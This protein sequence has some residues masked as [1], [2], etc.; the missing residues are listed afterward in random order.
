[1]TLETLKTHESVL[2]FQILLYSVIPS[3]TILL[4]NQNCYIFNIQTAVMD[5]TVSYLANIKYCYLSANMYEQ[6]SEFTK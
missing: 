5:K 2:I 4:A 6:R 1:M 3:L